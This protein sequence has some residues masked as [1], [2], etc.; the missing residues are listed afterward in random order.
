MSNAHLSMPKIHDLTNVRQGH[1]W[2]VGQLTAQHPQLRYLRKNAL[3][4]QADSPRIL[5][6]AMQ[7]ELHWKPQQAKSSD[8]EQKAQRGFYALKDLATAFDV[9]TNRPK[10]VRKFTA[11]D[12]VLKSDESIGNDVTY[13][14]VGDYLDVGRFLEGQPEC[15]GIAY[16]GNPT[17][18]YVTVYAD[19]GAVCTVD[20]EVLIRKQARM[21]RFV[22]WLEQQGV[23]CR[24]VG[25]VSNEMGHYEVQLKHYGDPVNLNDIAVVFH[26][27]WLRRI[28]FLAE[29]QSPTW[30]H[31]YG[32][33]DKWSRAMKSGYRADPADGLT[34]FISASMINNVQRVDEQFDRLRDKVEALITGE[35]KDTVAGEET[36]QR[37]FTKVYAV[38]L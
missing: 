25:V 31:G 16:M 9:F 29:E 11:E 19:V 24:I 27:D 18:L 1:G 22:D 4:V 33:P 15:F 37:D 36:L 38:E 21:L 34:V 2:H 30:E 35:G 6:D 14:V 8:R 26:S 3:V 5:M 10:E 28:I 32:M 23:R 13:D 20:A 17:G 7:H 12:I